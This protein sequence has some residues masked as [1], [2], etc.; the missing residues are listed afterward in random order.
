MGFAADA[1]GRWTGDYDYEVDLEAAMTYAK[2]TNDR[3]ERYVN[4]EIIPPVMSVLAIRDPLL[5]V[6]HSVVSDDVIASLRGTHGE[7]DMVFHHHVVP[8]SMVRSRAVGLALRPKRSGTVFMFKS[9]TR[10]ESGLLLNEQYWTIF[11]RG[12]TGGVTAGEA[13]P[14]HA[15]PEGLAETRPAATVETAI[16]TDQTF[17]YAAASGDHTPIHL[18]D[19][20]ARSVGLP[21]IIVHGLCTLAMVSAGTIERLAGGDPARLSRLAGRF[22]DIVFPGERLMTA[23]W[24]SPGSAAEGTYVFQTS[25]PGGRIVLANGLIAISGQPHLDT[26]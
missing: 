16:D 9:E 17:R 7:Q 19:H 18:S 22:S 11:Y 6:L 1:L 23:V 20:T 4:G 13:V 15:L 2:A 26:H 3:N 5:E 8:G 21:G 14:G 10:S 25:G 12:V 24:P